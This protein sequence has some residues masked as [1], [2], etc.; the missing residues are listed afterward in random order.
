VPPRFGEKVAKV[1]AVMASYSPETVYKT[2]VSASAAPET[3]VVGA[4]EP[5]IPIDLRDSWPEVGDLT[6]RMMYM[7][8]LTYLPDDILVKVDRASM[9]CSLESRAPF[10][11][12][13]VVEFAWSLPPEMKV[14]GGEG[15]HVL[16]Q[17]LYR[18]VPREI[19]DRPKMGFGVP[20]AQWLRGPLRPWAEALIAED[21]LRQEGFF[22]VSAV[23]QVWAEHLSGQHDRQFVVWAILMFQAWLDELRAASG[24]NTSVRGAAVTAPPA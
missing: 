14:A 2:L 5:P 21:R 6:Q 9:A 13:R 19:M 15:K 24:A 17:V 1:A 10:L 3:L 7:D 18:H 11:D 22:E 23:R 4:A 12:H 20:V 8:A 16:R